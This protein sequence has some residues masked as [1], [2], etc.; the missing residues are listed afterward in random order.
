MSKKIKFVFQDGYNTES[1]VIEYDEQ[2]TEEELEKDRLEFFFDKC[3]FLGIEAW[4]KEF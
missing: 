3:S 1:E 2:P 4:T